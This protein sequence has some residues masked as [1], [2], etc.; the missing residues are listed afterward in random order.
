MVEADDIH[1]R[2]SPPP[3]CC[4]HQ[5]LFSGVSHTDSL[6]HL[7]ALLLP[8]CEHSKCSLPGPCDLQHS[9]LLV[10]LGW[11]T[12]ESHIPWCPCGSR[13]REQAPALLHDAVQVDAAEGGCRCPVSV[14]QLC[15]SGRQGWEEA[16]IRNPI[17][18][19][20][21]SFLERGGKALPASSTCSPWSVR[22]WQFVC[23]NRCGQRQTS[24]SITRNK[25]GNCLFQQDL[26]KQEMKF[27]NG[28]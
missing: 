24:I 12:N 19:I 22:V 27:L 5:L 13:K 1:K 9:R 3:S 20:A 10:V 2:P 21:V 16:G 11:V 6:C 18:V 8:F 17:P 4:P 26:L 28:S 25:F 23:R 7:P 15:C 14:R